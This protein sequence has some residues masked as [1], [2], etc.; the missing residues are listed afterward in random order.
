MTVYSSLLVCKKFS[1]SD[2]NDVAEPLVDSK[3]LLVLPIHSTLSVMKN[4]VD[5]IHRKGQTFKYIKETFSR[6]SDAKIKVDIF[7]ATNK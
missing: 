3:D 6:I 7:L 1:S 2:K 5:D 4:F